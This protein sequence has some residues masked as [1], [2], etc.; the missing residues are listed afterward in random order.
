MA[1]TAQWF[2][3]QISTTKCDINEL[4]LIVSENL[5]F[6]KVPVKDKKANEIK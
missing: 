4:P 5:P 3:D 6:K 1:S 2:G